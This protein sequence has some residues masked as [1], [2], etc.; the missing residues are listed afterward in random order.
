[1]P[2]DELSWEVAVLTDLSVM[3]FPWLWGVWLLI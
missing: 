1:M 3:E 2:E